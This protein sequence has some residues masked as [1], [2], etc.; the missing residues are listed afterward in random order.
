[1]TMRTGTQPHFRCNDVVLP[2][3]GGGSYVDLVEELRRTAQRHFEEEQQARSGGGLSGPTS[4][5]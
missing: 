1:M 2:L 4:E 5:T 3:A